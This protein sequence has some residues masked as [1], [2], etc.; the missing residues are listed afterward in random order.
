MAFKDDVV[1]QVGKWGSTKSTNGVAQVFSGLG[2]FIDDVA[3]GL[4]SMF[5]QGETWT[6]VSSWLTS[7]FGKKVPSISEMINIIQSI[8][9]KYGIPLQQAIDVVESK[10]SNLPPSL[11]QNM[12][13]STQGARVKLLDERK[14]LVN[15][16]TAFENEINALSNT[17]NA[18]QLAPTGSRRDLTR[19]LS[20]GIERLVNTM[21]G[22]DYVQKEK[23]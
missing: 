17:A 13:K 8:S 1:A 2:K 9:R 23:V 5:G 7:L 10:I 15:K 20:S 22:E 11:S 6:Q 18:A 16:R 4:A 3:Y 12:K 21:E 19:D 14:R